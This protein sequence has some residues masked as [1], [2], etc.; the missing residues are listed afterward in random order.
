[1]RSALVVLSVVYMVLAGW[2]SVAVAQEVPP[3]LLVR[4]LHV[5]PGMVAQYEAAR[6]EAVTARGESGFPFNEAVL[7]GQGP[8][9][10]ILTPLMDGWESLDERL[11]WFREAQ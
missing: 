3:L 5:E 2:A 4:D 8:V 7:V 6:K 1:M 9:Y 10:R 11:G